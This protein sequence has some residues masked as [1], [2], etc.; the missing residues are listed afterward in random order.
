MTSEP[1][2]EPSSTPQEPPERQEPA[3]DVTRTPPIETP[4]QFTRAAALWSA[5]IAGFLITIV[6]LIFIAQNTESAQFAFLG[7]RWQLPLGVAI[8]LA[9][10]C[11]GLLTVAVGTVRIVQLRREAKKNLKALRAK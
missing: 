2:E 3:A 7:W 11:G 6:L 9:A 5:L 8:L 1:T 10:V 4:V